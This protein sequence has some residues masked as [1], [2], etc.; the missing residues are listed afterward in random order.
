MAW[1]TEQN[2]RPCLYLARLWMYTNPIKSSSTVW[3]KNHSN[4]S[5]VIFGSLRSALNYRMIICIWSTTTVAITHQNEESSRRKL[6]CYSRNWAKEDVLT[7]IL[8]TGFCWKVRSRLQSSPTQKWGRITLTLDNKALLSSIHVLLVGFRILYASKNI[9]YRSH[10][11][12]SFIKPSMAC[13]GRPQKF[14]FYVKKKYEFSEI[15]T[16][17]RI[18]ICSTQCLTGWQTVSLYVSHLLVHMCY[19]RHLQVTFSCV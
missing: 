8:P 15:T 18:C 4:T 12:N 10:F 7:F 14:I 11:Y 17:L 6:L 5:Y 19:G 3:I 2:S 13:G 9:Q 16:W 1:T